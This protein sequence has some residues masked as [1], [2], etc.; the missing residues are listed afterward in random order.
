MNADRVSERPVWGKLLGVML[1]VVHA[2]LLVWAV[3]GMIEWLVPEV[4][5]S[6]LSNPLF[7]DWLLLLHWLA[8]LT[9]AAVFLGGYCTRWSR[10]PV[11]LAAAYGTM[12]LVCA[13][14][15]FGYLNHD[16]RFVA[17]AIEY[18][19]YLMII[20]AIYRLPGLADR[21]STSLN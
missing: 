3:I 5:W 11:V 1:V 20:F 6:R 9:A 14:E 19:V 2:G 10:T 21:F 16:L 13:V 8:I 15:T 7:P 18:I 4:P 12:A 17:M